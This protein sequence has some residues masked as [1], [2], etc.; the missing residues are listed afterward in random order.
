MRKLVGDKWY[1]KENFPGIFVRDIFTGIE[2]L[3]ERAN[4][5][6]QE[7]I[8]IVELPCK[9]VEVKY[10]SKNFELFWEEKK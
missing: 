1:K 3:V 2:T 8:R 9:K 5:S 7:F 6:R 4:P 10:T